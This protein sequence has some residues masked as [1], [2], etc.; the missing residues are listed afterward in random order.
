MVSRNTKENLTKSKA[1]LKCETA[2][3]NGGENQSEHIDYEFDKIDLGEDD[4]WI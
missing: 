2:Y 1:S 4:Q 3:N